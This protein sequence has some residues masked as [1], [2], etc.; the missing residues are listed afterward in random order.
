MRRRDVLATKRR[1]GKVGGTVRS[2]AKSR[3]A[4]GRYRRARGM[5]REACLQIVEIMLSNPGARPSDLLS[6]GAIHK[7]LLADKS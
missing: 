1:A 5:F 3:A 6:L 7:V 4:R 2:A